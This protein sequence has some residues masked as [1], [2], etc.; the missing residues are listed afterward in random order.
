MAFCL[1]ATGSLFSS[2]FVAAQPIVEWVKSIA[3]TGYNA[4]S[5]IASDAQG[6]VLV[7]GIYRDEIAYDNDPAYRLTNQGKSDIVLIKMSESGE[8]DW[9]RTIGGSGEDKAYRMITDE[10]GSIFLTGSFERILRFGENQD[11]HTLE[12]RGKEDMFLAKFD[13]DGQIVW[14]VQSGGARSDQ[15][16]GLA[17]DGAGNVYVSGFFEEEAFFGEE[18]TEALSSKGQLDAYLVKYDANGALQWVRSIGGEKRDIASGVAVNDAGEAF[19]TGVTRGP[20]PMLDIDDHL[21]RGAPSGQ[22]DLFLARFSSDGELNR[23]VYSGGRGFDAGNAIDID[24]QGNL[25]IVGYFEDEALI[26]D[27]QGNTHVV[28][29]KSFDLLVARYDREGALLWARSAG[30]E[31]WD[32][33]YDIDVDELGNAYVTGFFRKSADF[34]GNDQSD[35]TGQG[36]AN[37]FVARYNQYGHIEGLQKVEGAKTEGAGIATDADGNV[38][39][40][41]LFIQQAM[42]GEGSDALTSTAYNSFIVKYEAHSLNQDILPD[43]ILALSEEKPELDLAQNYPNPFSSNTVFRIELAETVQ[44]QLTVHDVLGRVVE[45]IADGELASGIHRFFYDA[46][47]LADGKYFYT[48][49]TPS[50]QVTRIMTLIR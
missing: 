38:F 33:A 26:G 44:I 37:A 32:N 18:A 10:A 3:G 2:S 17:T 19:L 39:L 49:K 12:S 47:R 27:M 1:L 4:G 31:R 30:G 5:D 7:A 46:S 8:V 6:N 34:T 20:A 48:L 24:P 36:E 13:S 50:A 25:Y 40:T 45:E 16:I 29:G 22:D 35:I 15:G 23:L 14:S 11:T 9:I 43:E 41:G 42:F 28:T 21:V